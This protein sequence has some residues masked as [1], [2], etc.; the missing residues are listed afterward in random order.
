PD[1]T[2]APGPARLPRRAAR[3]GGG[4]LP[5]R[6][7]RRESRPRTPRLGPAGAGPVRR[8]R[9]GGR[10]P[11][12]VGR[13]HSG[14]PRRTAVR[15]VAEAAA[16]ADYN[17]DLADVL[18]RQFEHFRAEVPPLAGKRVVLK[19]NL[20]EYHRDK[21]INT[22]PRVVAAAIELCKHEGAAEVIVAEGPGHWRNL[23]YLVEACGLGTVLQKH[24]VRFVDLNHDEPVRM[25][26]L[27]QL[28]GLETIF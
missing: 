5:H 9:R 8:R 27:G 15:G 7:A 16:A 19:P 12:A 23:E 17:A 3:P 25:P 18:R 13:P 28:T 4:A 1:G 21:V 24:Q 14:G 26:N 2:D 6:P 10:V 20:V 22:D 11:A